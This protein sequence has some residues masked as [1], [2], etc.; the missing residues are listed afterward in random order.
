MNLL[1]IQEVH[2]F[3]DLYPTTKGHESQ[4]IRTAHSET[5]SLVLSLKLRERSHF[6]TMS[7]RF[8]NLLRIEFMVIYE[9]IIFLGFF[10]FKFPK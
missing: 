10:N 9:K 2:H 7:Q 6:P 1:Y 4:I 5:K 3:D 8:S